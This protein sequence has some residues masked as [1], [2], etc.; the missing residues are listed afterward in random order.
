MK[1]DSLYESLAEPVD[2]DTPV[3]GRTNVTKTI[4]TSDESASIVEPL[5]GT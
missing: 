1:L 5:I 2:A 3:P 4:E